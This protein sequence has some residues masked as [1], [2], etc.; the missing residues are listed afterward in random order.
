MT[1]T[2][3]RLWRIGFAALLAVTAM[4]GEAV[5]ETVDA[6]DIPQQ[7]ELYDVILEYPQPAWITGQ[8]EPAALLDRSEFYRDHAGNTFLLEQIPDGQAFESWQSLF[9]VAAEEVTVGR[10]YSMRDFI[11]LAET[12]NR[13]A[14]VEGGYAAQ[15]LKASESD[16][17]VFMVCGSTEKGS[18][19]IGY[20]PDVGEAS[21]WRFMIYEDTYVKVYQRWRGGPFAIDDR[22]DWPVNEA[23]LQ[24]MVRRMTD[25]I[26]L[27]DNV[28]GR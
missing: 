1:Q 10:Q 2:S 28:P 26:E 22:A 25:G 4:R 13:A 8:V 21:L 14:C 7:I 12:Q 5:A 18:T 23:E 15:V 11:G 3:S 19:A 27:L 17:I 9:A 6:A 24:E 20:G 16:S